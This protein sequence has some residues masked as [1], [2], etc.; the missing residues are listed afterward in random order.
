MGIQRI[1]DRWL[2]YFDKLRDIDPATF[3]TNPVMRKTMCIAGLYGFLK[4]TVG[5]EKEVE[6]ILTNFKE[7]PMLSSLCQGGASRC[8][9]TEQYIL[10][11][12]YLLRYWP[13]L[14]GNVLEIG[15]GYG[16]FCRLLLHAVPNIESYTFVDHP[17]ML[18]LAH[19]FLDNKSVKFVE[20]DDIE[21]ILGYEYDLF[22]SNFCLTEVTDDFRNEI[23]EKIFPNVSGAYVISQSETNTAATTI[24]EFV[25][26]FRSSF[27][28][29]RIIEYPYR[30]PLFSIYVGK[31]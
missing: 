6:Q 4:H 14:S 13:N 15:G 3:S 28:T 12:C 24:T 22:I 8:V 1:D 23:Y 10:Q 20:I 16:G 25:K 30:A 29:V 9:S 21:G 27:K 31:N 26:A 11:L 5:F 7:S 17:S 18:R 2:D 19:P